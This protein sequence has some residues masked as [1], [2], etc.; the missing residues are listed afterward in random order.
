MPKKTDIHK[1]LLIGS[2]PIV[3]G[4]AAEFDYAGV[5]AC[6]ALREEGYRVVLVNSNPATIMTDP[7]MADV[8]YIEP[9]TPEYLEKIIEKERPCALLSTMGGQT[10]LNLTLALA[11]SGVL[12]KYGVALLGADVP[13]IEKAEDRS[14][15][16]KAVEKVGGQ[17]PKSRA[18]KEMSEVEQALLLIGLPIM[19]RPSF[20]LGGSGSGIAHTEEEL[21][22][23]CKRAFALAPHHEVLL[24][25]ALIGWK[26]FEMEVM[27]DKKD[28]CLLICCLENIDALGI[29]TGDSITVAP[30]LTLT[31]KEHQRMRE[32]SFAI[33][34][35]IGVETGGA[36]VQFAIHPEDGRM[37]VIEMNP[38][39]SRSSAL[40][41][42]AT[43]FPIAKIAAKLA[44]GYT[45]DEL[46]C[47]LTGG[48]I[49]ASFEPTIDYVV[50]KI[51]RF[52]FEK[53]P[54]APAKLG[55]Q[56]Q[57]VGEAMAIGRT[58]SEALLKAMRSLDIPS[59]PVYSSLEEIQRE[60]QE[61][62]PFRLWAIFEAFRSGIPSIDIY[63]LTKIDPWFLGQI[64]RLVQEERL[65]GKKPLEKE[66]LFLLKQR[67]FSDAQ[68]ASCISVTEEEIRRR[69]KEWGIAPVYKR[70]DSCAAEFATS[71]AYLY[72]TYEEECEAEPSGRPKLLLLGSGPIRIGQGME[73]DY[74]CVHALEAL[75]D[76]GYETIMVNCN[77]ETVSTDFTSAD[78]LY[79]APLTAEDVLDIIDKEKP[80]G[81]LVQYGGQTP[82]HLAEVLAQERVP[83]LGLSTELIQKTE[84][85]S[86][87]RELLGQM[88]LK[89]PRN[90]MVSSWEEGQRA[91]EEIGFPVILRPSFVLGGRAMKVIGHI[92]ELENTLK[93]SFSHSSRPLLLEQFLSEAIEVDIDA[94]CDGGDVLIPGLIEHVEP[95]GVHSGDSAGSLPPFSLSTSLQE[96]LKE[97]T[98]KLALE[99]RLIGLMNVQFAIQGQEIYVLEVNPRASRTVP[100]VT[101]ATGIDLVK[102]ATRA[103][104][105]VSLSEQIQLPMTKALAFAVKEAVL[106]FSKFPGVDPVLGP[107]MKATGEVMGHG[108]SFIEAYAKAQ[109]ASGYPLPR[110]GSGV[111]LSLE[112]VP[113][114]T[115]LS[116]ARA[117]L[118]LSFRIFT[119]G[120]T[121]SLLQAQGVLCERF[122]EGLE[123]SEE[124]K[125][126]I[127]LEKEDAFLR[128]YAAKH[129]ICY[130]TTKESAEALLRAV[131]LKEAFGLQVLQQAFF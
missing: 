36:N 80:Q 31:D 77:P 82:L 24:D 92:E 51:P 5:Q 45:L 25:E 19:V 49:P 41:S 126:V 67:G 65:M 100:F 23:L 131:Q 6:K 28:N 105:G 93:E 14:M 64:Q 87:F 69:R 8:T 118:E 74:C 71:C 34:R 22:A 86:L 99:L 72:A 91:V 119:K 12:E 15:F 32:S 66:D 9:L 4:Q 120:E 56:M 29:H 11:R 88:G 81:V 59:F 21:F 84:D 85:R 130:A 52:S 117:L 26:E 110:N 109:I 61:A 94:V 10:A 76:E 20:I 47:D 98:K 68:I 78:K 37:L 95:A 97:Q 7:H 50:I 38:R 35:E 44:V 114:E 104:L 103:L 96:R 42:K 62:G 43:G 79:C 116:W 129:G 17:L 127:A 73:F 115:A 57:S 55:T 63:L 101:K 122:Q 90:R 46:S 128:R 121:F 27:R 40:A 83:L 33:L 111:I 113:K 70:V 39:V 60:L 2:G 102:I 125:W 108:K 3:I 89:Q 13:V 107:E 58:F 1:I 106:P 53:F 18:A 48:Q 30:S 112:G 75:Q 124:I 16:R 123:L 54:S